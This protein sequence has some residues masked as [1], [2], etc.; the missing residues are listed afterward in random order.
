MRDFE[1]TWPTAPM[2]LPTGEHRPDPR[3]FWTPIVVTLI[4]IVALAIIATV[5]P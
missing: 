2:H 3:P 1:D 4:G 5:W